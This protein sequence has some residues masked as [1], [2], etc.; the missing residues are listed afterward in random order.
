MHSWSQDGPKMDSRCS[1]DG[2][3][4]LPWSQDGPKMVPRCS[5]MA[6]DA[7]KMAQDSCKMGLRNGCYHRYYGRRWLLGPSSAILGPSWGCLGP[8]W[9]RLGAILGRLGTN[10]ASQKP[11]KIDPKLIRNRSKNRC[12]KGSVLGGLRGSF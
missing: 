4:M 7:P 2:P 3:K 9:G 6:Q 5:K 11:P 10:L 12:I 8:S 1:Q